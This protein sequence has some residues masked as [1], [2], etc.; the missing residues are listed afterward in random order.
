MMVAG[1]IREA[2]RAG[3]SIAILVP[4]L[5]LA[6]LADPNQFPGQPTRFSA[7]AV[8]GGAPQEEMVSRLIV[9]PRYRVGDQLNNALRTRDASGLSKASNVPM[10]VVRPMSGGAHVI[11]LDQPVTLSGAR[12][13][14]AR[15]M[16]DNSVEMAEPDRL[17]RPLAITPTDPDYAT[18][19]WNLKAPSSL[20]PGSANLPN[21]WSITTGSNTV[22]VAVIDTGYRPHADLGAVVLPGYDFITDIPAAND[23]N[24]RDADAQDPGDWIT[25][26]ENTT[27]GGLFYGCGVVNN[28][29]VPINQLSPSSWHGTHVAGII[30][31]QMNNGIGITGVAPNIQILP[32][33]VLGKCG[34]YDSD[35]IDGMRWA[36]GIAVT[37]VPSN[38]HPAQVLNMSL[39]EDGGAPCSSAY[40]SAVTDVINAGKVIVIAAG[41]DGTSTLSSPANCTGVIAVTANAIDGDNSWFAT[42]G[43]GT[44]ISAPGGGCGGT[45]YPNNCTTANSVGVYSLW[46]TGLTTPASDGYTSYSGTSMAAPHVT[47]VAA[48]MLSLDPTLTPV[49]IKSY[50]QSSAR[51]H[52]P[53]TIC[54]QTA[55]FGMCGAGLLDAYQA[56]NAV[57]PSPIPPPVVT[58]GSIP[59]VVTP[60]TVVMLSGS[61]VAGAGRSITSYAWA[62]LTGATVTISNANTANANFTAS[63][64]GTYSFMLTATDSGGQTGTATA[65]LVVSLPVSMPPPVVTLGSIPSVVA[66]GDTVTLSGSAVAGA[67][68]S[69]TS[70]AWVQQS[71]PATVVIS[72]ANTANANFTASATGSYTFKL[73]ANDNGGQAGT[74]TVV[75]LVSAPVAA[76][77][78]VVTLGSMPSVVA[79]GDIVTL[80]GSA[81]A[82]AGRSITSYA[83]AQQTGPTT[84]AISNANAANVYF[85]APPAGTYSFILTAT[86]NG[87]QTGTATAVIRVN[88]PPVLNAV[89]AQTIAA[90]Q[91]LNFTVTASD[92]DGDTPIFHWVSLPSG[93]TLSATGNFSWPNAAPAGNYT[94]T[95][96]ASDY[97]A[98]SSQ[99]T[100][101]ITVT[102]ASSVSS[103]GG[104]GGGGSLD[105][106]SLVVLAL[107]AAGLRLRR[108]YANPQK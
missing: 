11:C 63:A 106:E 69:I 7:L 4:A 87:G 9:K 25:G 5:A 32:V 104:G 101:N 33:R 82:G 10:S 83:W 14:A 19:Q 98:N 22:T 37:G 56:L 94:M 70:Y 57:K 75:I 54:A 30:A 3:V 17:K 34:G 35:I 6:A 44:T 26:T 45:S 76:P 21:A 107:L 52:P 29:N 88:S 78:P 91:A 12:V 100:I 85:T 90:G 68:R 89:P 31:A 47:G 13:I 27:R 95:Y 2:L 59:S 71:G 38:P 80:S 64:T 60:G 58:L 93:T 15:L 86:D 50:L 43:P 99:G 46:N 16:R 103:S 74:A 73:T 23:G 92:V 108:R 84:V 28:H 42:I 79:P 72:N 39:G 66:P 1:T 48:L 8:V 49:Q 105:T 36:A 97:Y 53:G 96:Y 55:N 65:V 18:Y 20:N 40:Q 51:P 62:Q 24:G 102:A 81:V 61:A 41:N 67:G 77:P